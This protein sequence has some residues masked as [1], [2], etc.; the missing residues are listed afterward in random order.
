VLRPSSAW[1]SRRETRADEEEDLVQG[2]QQASGL[3][4]I[5]PETT[6]QSTVLAAAMNRTALSQLVLLTSSVSEDEQLA[7]AGSNWPPALEEMW[8]RMPTA[9]DDGVCDD[10]VFPDGSPAAAGRL[11]CVLRHCPL[12]GGTSSAAAL[13]SLLNDALGLQE[14]LDDYQEDMRKRLGLTQS[15]HGAKLAALLPVGST[16]VQ[17]THCEDAAGAAVFGVLSGLDGTFDV[18]SE[19]STLQQLFET[20]AS[21]RGWDSTTLRSEAHGMEVAEEPV[22]PPLSSAKLVATGYSLL[23]PK[24]AGQED[25]DQAASAADES[26][27]PDASRR[28]QATLKQGLSD[29][30]ASANGGGLEGDARLQGDHPPEE[31]GTGM[32]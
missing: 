3:I 27:L 28:T 29:G 5:A 2:L 21:S 12:F 32:D 4:T 8:A 19:P 1:R 20:I 30:S 18:C 26:G 6:E 11:L 25:D 15:A 17:L 10:E 7:A 31:R 14:L 13:D 24:L 23:W 9:E 16:A 22:P